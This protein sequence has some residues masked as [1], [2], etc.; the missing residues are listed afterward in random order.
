MKAA[1]RGHFLTPLYSE[2]IMPRISGRYAGAKAHISAQTSSSSADPRIPGADEHA[3]GPAGGEPAPAGGT[4]EAGLVSAGAYRPLT[5]HD[6][7]V[8]RRDFE[9]IQARGRRWAHAYLVVRALPNGSTSCRLGFAISKQVGIAVVRN[10]LRR[11]LR[12][13][14]RN[15]PVQSGWDLLIVARPA[16][17]QASFW[18]LR[19][20][21]LKLL[22]QAGL[23][24]LSDASDRAEGGSK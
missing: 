3:R 15:T 1:K 9:A 17:V 18:Q 2:D 22:A 11:R 23:V 6:R 24:Q 4:L 16:A 20:A 19:A 5:A 21:L 12:E 7:L 13:V 10:R 8:Q 14:M